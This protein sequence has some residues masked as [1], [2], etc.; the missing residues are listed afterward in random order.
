M[1]S[2][3]FVIR[4]ETL[5][6]GVPNCRRD[7]QLRQVSGWSEGECGDKSPCKLDLQLVHK[8]KDCKL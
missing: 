8:E 3:T 4:E 6:Q 1:D 5:V 2:Q 7:L